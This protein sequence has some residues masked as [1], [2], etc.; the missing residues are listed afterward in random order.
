MAAWKTLMLPVVWGES[1]AE[2]KVLECF[3]LPT[4]ICCPFTAQGLQLTRWLFCR[5]HTDLGQD[6]AIEVL[7]PLIIKTPEDLSQ[8]LQVCMCSL[9]EVE[10]AV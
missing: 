2:A 1:A 10:S 9:F 3:G 7:R 4:S 5:W 8:L 6:A